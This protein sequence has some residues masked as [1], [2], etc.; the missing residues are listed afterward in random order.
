MNVDRIGTGFLDHVEHALR[1]FGT[2][3]L[4][5]NDAN[6][7]YHGPSVNIP[8]VLGVNRHFFTSGLET[9][10]RIVI[11]IAA[12]YLFIVYCVPSN[13]LRTFKALLNS[14]PAATL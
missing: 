8:W 6:H 2:F 7:R 10:T 14:T 13:V 9:D 12:I 11:A 4:L 5:W 3:S 1:P